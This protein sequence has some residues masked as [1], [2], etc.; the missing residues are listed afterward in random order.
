MTDASKTT[1]FAERQL[2]LFGTRCHELAERVSAGVMPFVQA[3]D[4]AYEAAIWSGVCDSVGDDA[5]QKIMA[6]AFMGLQRRGRP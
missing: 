6:E 2:D 5:V 1:S 4:L 3:V